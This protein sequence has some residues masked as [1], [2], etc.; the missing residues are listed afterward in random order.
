MALTCGTFIPI[1]GLMIVSGRPRQFD[2]GE[3]LRRIG[4]T[5]REHGYDGASFEQLVADSGLS[6]SSLYNAFG[7]KEALYEKALDVYVRDELDGFLATLEQGDGGADLLR[8]FVETWREP[9]IPNSKG[10]L[11]GKL[12]MENAGSGGMVRQESIVTRTLH[13]YW[14]G[15]TSLVS[16]VKRRKKKQELSDSELGAVMLAMLF[17][18]MVLARNG[19]NKAIVDEVTEG[20]KKVIGID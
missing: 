4:E 3:V 15:F 10:C 13:R 1:F 9:Y 6:R 16:R 7:G 8:G 12:L 2:E 11:F 20:A 18:V 19:R 17:G 14:K 5:F